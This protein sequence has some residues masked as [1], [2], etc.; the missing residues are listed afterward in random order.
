MSAQ[1]RGF[2][3]LEVMVAVALIGIIA[4][5]AIFHIPGAGTAEQLAAEAERFAAL[6]ELSH[7]EAIMLGEQRA[8]RLRNGGYEFMAL[9]PAGQWAAIDN[10]DIAQQRSIPAGMK[11]GLTIEGRALSLSD[12]PMLPQILLLASG[13]TTAFSA[14]FATADN[15]G[16]AVSGDGLGRFTVQRLP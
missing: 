16:I 14:R 9:D 5:I 15:R 4:G 11:L 6:A 7:Q 3:L 12:T 1:A 2:T 8:I 10:A 13:E